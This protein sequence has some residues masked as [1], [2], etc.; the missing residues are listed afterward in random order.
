MELTGLPLTQVLTVLGG[1]AGAVVILYLLKLRRRQ[2]EVPFVHLW[3]E[4]LAET[5]TTR[6]FSALKRLLSLL[7]ALTIVSALAFAMG[8]PEY[9]TTTEGAR[10]TVVLVDA[11]ASMQATDVAPDRLGAA[12]AEVE[13]LVEGLRGADR[14]LIAQ[15]D[16]TTVPLSPITDEARLLREA[17]GRLEPTDV[18]ADLP[19]GLRFALDVLRGQPG[20][21]VVLVTD[22][23]LG[24]PG[25]AGAQLEEA[26]VEVQWIRVGEGGR[27]VAITAFS[28]R[29][30]PLDKSRSQVLVELWNPGEVDE[31]VELTLLGDGEE[32]DV[33]RLRIGGG[34]RLRRVFENV[35]GADRTLE[36]RLA[37]AD[38][39]RD[40]QP[41]DDRAYARL[42]ER[43][44][45]RVQAVT[46][47]NLYLSA[48]L[49]LDEYLEVVE[50]RP[51]DYPAPG[52]FDITIFDAWVPP[53]PPDTHAIYI[54]PTLTEGVQGP[55]A[56][57]GRAARPFFDRVDHDHPVV[58][59]M[60]LRDV[61]MAEALRVELAP[62]DRVVAGDA[63]VPLIVTGT[64]N[65]K[66]IVA[67]L[68]DVRRSDLPLRIAWPLLLL[69]AIDHFVQE[70]A[71]YLSSHETGRTWHIPVAPG[72]TTATLVA[73]SGEERA[74]PVVEGRAIATGRRAGFYRLRTGELEDVFAANLGPSEEA[75][76]APPDELEPA[77]APFTPPAVVAPAVRTEIW[78]L[79]VLGALG[80]LLA[81]WVTYHRR[82]TV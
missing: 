28:V 55:F 66:R 73:P 41:A 70:D 17:L 29:R 78:M 18:A 8:E 25:P 14:M 47:G 37:L 16:S 36:A 24:P 44:R 35:S 54:Y 46:E 22:G 13:R 77:G 9:V 21:R 34:E 64:R 4:V 45:A 40:A 23:L 42:P 59:F 80:V 57:T 6:L 82:I 39:S 67:L 32:L 51:A 56:V 81:E 20:P 7:V 19:R 75:I 31:G 10:T 11:S 27:N 62:G 53:S 65:G 63:G 61:N 76:L 79:L 50:V 68:F 5:Q 58:R 69:N 48:A 15:L 52:R 38:R 71:G 1:F 3:R 49:L 43:R 74:V 72:A 12:R 60:A 33:Q 2:V 30:Y 26:G